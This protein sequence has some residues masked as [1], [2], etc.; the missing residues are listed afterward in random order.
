MVNPNDPKDPKDLK[1]PAPSD[2]QAQREKDEITEAD[3]DK[4]SG[5]A[6]VYTKPPSG[7]Q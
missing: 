2:S 1:K 7:T 6:I 4:V 3:L 5:G